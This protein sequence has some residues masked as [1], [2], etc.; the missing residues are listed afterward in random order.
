MVTELQHLGM[1]GGEERRVLLLSFSVA[2]VRKFAELAPEEA[3]FQLLP[4]REPITNDTL[5]AVATCAHGVGPHVG[6][7]DADLVHRAHS[8]DLLVI[9]YTANDFD[10][11]VRLLRLGVDGLI[12]DN[13]VILRRAVVAEVVGDA[14]TGEQA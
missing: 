2:A 4:P 12:G 11:A 10:E 13:P 3:R 8:R 9:P 5:D 7:V 14:A 1:L 6:S